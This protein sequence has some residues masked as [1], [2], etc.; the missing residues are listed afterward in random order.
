M[1][2]EFIECN[3][4]TSIFYIIFSTILCN[5]N[6]IVGT[7]SFM[8]TYFISYIAHF[9]THIECFYL[10]VYSITHQYHHYNP[11]NDI[12][13]YILECVIEY[14]FLIDSVIFKYIVMWLVNID[15]WYINEWV[16]L[17]GY[18]IYTTVHN[19]NYAMLKVNDYHTYHHIDCH[20]NY[21][22]DILD[23]IFNTKNENTLS[24]ENTLHYIPNIIVSFIIVYMIKKTITENQVKVTIFLSCIILHY[25]LIYETYFINQRWITEKIGKCAWDSSVI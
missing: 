8:Y 6:F 1:I 9:L 11:K 15:L 21:G 18:I 13:S 23:F 22:P 14:L 20:T 10:N 17:F 3:F 19:I 2:I 7:L 25:W 4:K 12:V 16:L 5:N 24:C